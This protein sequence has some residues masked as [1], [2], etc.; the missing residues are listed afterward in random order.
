MQQLIHGFSAANNNVGANAIEMN[1]LTE[2]FGVECGVC[3]DNEGCPCSRAWSIQ[4]ADEYAIAL[5]LVFI[6]RTQTRSWKYIALE[7]WKLFK[8]AHEF[9]CNQDEFG[10]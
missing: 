6:L 4:N 9:N 5:L 10:M 3:D 7:L 1:R 8:T 2:G